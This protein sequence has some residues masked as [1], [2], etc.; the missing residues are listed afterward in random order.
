MNRE[1]LKTILWLRWRLTRNQWQRA[2]GFG[3]VLAVIVAVGAV[4]LGGISFVGGLLGAALGLGA[5]KPEVV[6]GI[7]FGVTVAFLFFWL[8][9]LLAE[10]QRAETID[11]QRLMHLPVALGQMFVINYVASHFALSLILMVPAMTGLA[12]GLTFSRGPAM[13][14]LLPLAWS[15]VFMITAW[16]YC[17]RGWLAAMMSNPRR[18]RAIIMGITL[19]FIL[20]FQVPNLYFNVLGGR[21]R[22]ERPKNATPETEQRNRATRQTADQATFSQLIAVQKFIPPL[23]LPYGALGL[24]EHRL[25]PALLGAFG[26]FGLGVVGLRRAYRTTVKFYQGETGGQA[27]VVRGAPPAPT[28][29]AASAKARK[30]LLELRLPFV[31]EQAAA[32]ALGTFRSMLRA[33]EVKLAWGTAFLVTVLVGAS[34]LFRTAPTIPPAAKPF[35]VT[36]AMTFSLFMLVQFLANQFGF[37]RQGFRAFVLAPVDRR[38]LLLGKNLATWPVGATFGLLLLTTISIWLRLPPSAALAAVFQLATLLLVGSLAGNL[39]SILVPFR[40][41]A[42]SMKPTKM[43]A[44]AMLTMVLCQ[45]LFPMVMVPVFVP[46]L[47]EWLWQLAGWPVWVPVNLILSALLATLT[48]LLYWQTLAPLGRL[49]QRREIKILNTVTAEQE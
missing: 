10:L 13:L 46:P 40:I 14:L 27:G 20:I 23:W 18:R 6:M 28:A 35:I 15:M 17:L 38:L 2:G 7:W 9:G 8:I 32:V 25:A 16:T 39:L 34:L 24:A 45:F 11:L 37:D 1:Q 42:G 47:L 44:L 22:F 30:T 36:G 48:A 4:G 5:A 3:A 29:T 33:P 12:L 21:Q 31:P 49:L 26:C 19:G 41:A 43:P